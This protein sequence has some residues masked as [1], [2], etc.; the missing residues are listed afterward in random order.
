MLVG[1]VT[2]VGERWAGAV[3][4]FTVT[5]TAD[6]ADGTCDSDCSLREAADAASVTS[7]ASEIDFAVNG[8]FP[9]TLGAIVLTAEITVNGNGRADTVLDGGNS[10]RVFATDTDPVTLQHLTIENGETVPAGAALAS[11]G[12]GSV[13]LVDCLVTGNVLDASFISNGG[14]IATGGSVNVTDSTFSDNHA[15]SG[16]GNTGIGG[17]IAGAAVTVTNSTF[18]G[19]SAGS[20]GGAFAGG[21]V[22]VTSSTFD[23][24][25]ANGNV[26]NPGDPA[27]GG[28]ILG[29]GPV[30]V[31]NGST[32]TNNT[33]TA[34]SG[35]A[36]ANFGTT[37][38]DTVTIDASTIGGSGGNG[39]TAGVN[40]GGVSTAAGAV[41][42]RN[43]ASVIGNTATS[44]G[45]GVD[46]AGAFDATDA[47][48]SGNTS[49]AN[50][51]GL[52]TPAGVTLQNSHV[53]DN[54]VTGLSGGGMAAAGPVTIAA[55]TVDGNDAVTAGGGIASSGL[56]RVDGSTVN[57]NH[58]T[59]GGGSGGGIVSSGGVTLRNG[60]EVDDN[61]VPGS[62]GGIGTD[63][64]VDASGSQVNGNQAA[65]G[66]GGGI[67][68]SGQT[69][70]LVDMEI[71]G[72][73]AENLGGAFLSGTGSNT[74]TITR[75][76]IADNTASKV[77]GGLGIEDVTFDVSASTLSGN[78]A[79]GHL[80][81]WV[82]HFERCRR[83]DHQLDVRG[84]LHCR[85][86]WRNCRQR[87]E[88]QHDDLVRHHGRQHE[89][90]RRGL[91]GRVG[92]GC[93]S[94][95]DLLVE[96]RRQLRRRDHRL[97]IQPDL[98]RCG[99]L[100]VRRVERCGRRGPRLARARGRRAGHDCDDGARRR[101]PGRGSR[102][103]RVPAAVN[104]S[105]RCDASARIGM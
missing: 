12:G 70:S 11:N 38:A 56:V 21:T 84:Q 29:G 7:G 61:V 75:T 96:H 100:H 20:A 66:V 16:P 71:R 25:T 46:S 33:A 45:G 1:A 4:T 8:T 13:N 28:A 98:W 94:R 14:A 55:S 23:G 101:Q 47:T 31:N 34:S 52:D 97:R 58:V 2:V 105:A 30:L 26:A 19:N 68:V 67:Q 51:G 81:R 91:A 86:G 63:G 44:N 5:K 6:T 65:G 92:V 90:D 35:G 41:T 59:G 83:H 27:G 104:R 37:A 39:N 43:G 74:A 36:I 77:V 79:A 22:T 32:F 103:E 102:R 73:T 57:G 78:T 82:G 99:Q 54:H 10:T 87:S 62:G 64:S 72:N 89:S 40:G 60:A 3:T 76:T 95:L 49:S 9:I 17:A 24:N 88:R 42:L 93:R 18:T 80:C 15:I 53:S 50:G 48:V 69:L 85:C